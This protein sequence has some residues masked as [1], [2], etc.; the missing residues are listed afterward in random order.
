MNDSASSA[1]LG[2]AIADNVAA[3][4]EQHPYPPPTDDLE[5]YRRLWDQGRRRAEYHLLWPGECY[6][7][8]RSVLVAGSGTVQAAH[9]AL[10]WPRAP[11][12]GIDV[13]PRASPFAGG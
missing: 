12:V 4:Y 7:E 2:A 11:V 9:Y 10:R 13:T 3:F 8:D 6:R 5:S 1:A